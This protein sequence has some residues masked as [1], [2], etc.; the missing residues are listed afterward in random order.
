MK[1]MTRILAGLGMIT[2]LTAPW[3]NP[4]LPISGILA[5]DAAV[6]LLGSAVTVLARL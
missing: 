5:I 4:K 6:L 3:T 1:R 2:A